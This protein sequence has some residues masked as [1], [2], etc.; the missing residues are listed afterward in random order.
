MKK[1][2]CILLA[3][4]STIF[5]SSSFAKNTSPYQAVQ[6][7]VGSAQIAPLDYPTDISVTNLSSR[8]VDIHVPAVGFSGRLFSQYVQHVYAY[9]PDPKRVILINYQ[10]VVFFDE[11]VTN[12]H[13]ITVYN[14]RNKEIAVVS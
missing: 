5:L 9:D 12:H 6:S 3:I 2:I 8:F 11:L 4:T 10:G 7:A 1:I 13:A 14:L